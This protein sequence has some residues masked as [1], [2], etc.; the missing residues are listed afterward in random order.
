[1]LGKAECIYLIVMTNAM[2]H[3][4]FKLQIVLKGI[5]ECF[6]MLLCKMFLE[7]KKSVF[8]EHN[9]TDSALSNH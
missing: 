7:A 3:N 6:V 1:M 5:N 9:K 8:L 2:F 4:N